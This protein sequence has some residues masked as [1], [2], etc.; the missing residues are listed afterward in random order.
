MTGRVEEKTGNELEYART[1]E[2]QSTEK[3][4]YIQCV[5]IR[6]YRQS[7]GKE[8]VRKTGIVEEKT[9]TG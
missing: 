5:H 9:R 3:N 1:G 6:A 8:Y 7:R 2:K 4:R